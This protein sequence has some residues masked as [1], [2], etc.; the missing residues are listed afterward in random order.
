MKVGAEVIDRKKLD[1]R[2][3]DPGTPILQLRARD[4]DE[5]T[6]AWK[7]AGGEVISTGGKPAS[8]GFNKLVL[9]RDPNG[10]MVEMLPAP[11]SR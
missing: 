3:Q 8:L 6:R 1:T 4:V 9:L 2:T 5:V 7:A 11:P 10:V